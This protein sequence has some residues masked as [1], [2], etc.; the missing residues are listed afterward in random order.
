MSDDYELD[1][2]VECPYCGHSPLHYRYCIEFGCENG[3]REVFF[4]DIEIEGMGDIVECEECHGT[5]V[6]WWCPNCGKNLSGDKELQ[7]QFDR[8]ND[9]WDRE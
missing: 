4:D 9:E 6:E 2:E 7:K 3:F 1:G 5:G 8:I